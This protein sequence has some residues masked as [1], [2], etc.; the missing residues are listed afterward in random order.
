MLSTLS[1]VYIVPA[2]TAA[3][4]CVPAAG[5]DTI[6][7]VSSHQHR[8]FAP[9]ER[10]VAGRR[11]VARGLVGQRILRVAY[12]HI[13]YRGWDLGYHDQSSRRLIT[14]AAEWSAP[15]W[16]AQRFHHLDFGVELTTDLGETW[17][18]TWDSPSPV[19]GESI[20]LQR[21]PVSER[22]AVWD[23]T[24]R[25]PWRSCLGSPI[26][27]VVLRFHAWSDVAP[28]FWCTRVSMRFGETSV[29]VLLGDRDQAAQ[30]SPCADN[31]AVLWEAEPL[32]QWERIDDLV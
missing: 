1:S 12:V 5:S 27:D 13:D 14:A 21:E 23:V 29:E 2:R 10:A 15:T 7:F 19:N 32:P 16:D 11:A 20:C 31:I 3:R 22:G 28:R 6:T 9:D 17:G 26:S 18:I 8:G 4:E 24:A 30:L 25:E